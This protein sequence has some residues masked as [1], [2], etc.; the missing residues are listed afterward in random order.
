MFIRS[1]IKDERG[2]PLVEEGLLIGLGI[3]I[4]LTILALVTGIMNWL[5]ELG[6][7]LPGVICFAQ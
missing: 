1:L 7:Q 6:N 2:S 4:F 5:E 3:V